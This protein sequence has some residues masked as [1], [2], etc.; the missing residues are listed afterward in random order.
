MMRINSHKGKSKGCKVLMS[1]SCQVMKIMVAEVEEDT[2]RGTCP[3]PSL[4]LILDL[5]VEV[6]PAS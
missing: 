3:S 4:V 5:L 6:S 1:L 2:T